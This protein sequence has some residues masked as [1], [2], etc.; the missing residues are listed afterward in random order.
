MRHSNRYPRARTFAL[1]AL[2]IVAVPIISFGIYFHVAVHMQPPAIGDTRPLPQERIRSGEDAYTCGNNWIRKNT[3]GLW[4]LY[5]EGTPYE[6][7]RAMGIL[8]KELI[9]RQEKAFVDRI[10][11]LIPSRIY[12]SGL[13]TVVAWFC[14]NLDRSIPEEYR[15]EISGVS[16]SASNAF[17]DIGSNYERM[18]YY[19]AAHDIGHAL[20]G[21]HMVGC[22]SFSV[23][24]TSSADGSLLVGRNF[25][26]YVGDAFAKEKIVCF[27]NPTDGRRFMMVTWGGMIGAVSGMNECGLTVTINAAT[28]DK[29]MSAATPISIIA[30]E[31]LQYAT[32]IREA[33]AI[34]ARRQSFVSESIMIGSLR[35]NGTAIIEKSPTMTALFESRGSSI[36]CTNHFQSP[37][38]TAR[39]TAA[40]TG[41]GNA[42]RYRYRRMQEL[43]RRYPRMST[44]D[45]AT[46]L[47][48]RHGLADRD[49]G[50]GNEKAVNQLIAHHS[51][52]FHPARRMVWVSTSPFQLGEY[53]AYDLSEVFSPSKRRVLMDDINREALTIPPDPF[54]SSVEYR[55]F[56]RVIANGRAQLGR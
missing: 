50:M 17:A 15:Q 48:D 51:I 18:V 34:A 43:I 31:I 13:W 36:I 5:V 55:T 38:F 26:F 29:P 28:S 23:W 9:Y 56:L 6:R 35:D 30:R 54:L 3:R 19:H 41:I 14:R 46:I 44:P 40:D 33:F 8:S 27:V 16:Q 47:R 11:E 2:I 25:D 21:M 7:G 32:T 22:T 53:L 39:K 24:D 52:I 1:G 4:E 49:I 20:Q 45:V 42:S 37:V 12:V 10:H